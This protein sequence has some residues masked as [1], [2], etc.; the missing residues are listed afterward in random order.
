MLAAC[1]PAQRSTHPGQPS[2]TVESSK[3]SF[4][5]STSLGMILR[6]QG[7][8]FSSKEPVLFGQRLVNYRSNPIRIVNME[9]VADPGLTA[10]YVGH[11]T[12][13]RGCPGAVP[14]NHP[15]A[16]QMLR[17]S[18][19]GLYPIDVEPRSLVRTLVFKLE[20]KGATGISELLARC[21][22]Y[23]TTVV[24]TL[25]DGSEVEVGHG[26][27]KVVGVRLVPPLP[28]AGSHCDSGNDRSQATEESGGLSET[29]SSGLAAGRVSI[30]GGAAV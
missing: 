15:S 25:E 23:M 12:C 26:S 10:T 18:I 2:P 14:L 21:E 3:I 7:D 13:E 6:E 27:G 24:L 1:T 16:Q 9:L 29:A 19:D 20:L 4:A 5:D 11:S 22:L 28:A 30:W 17:T 8:G